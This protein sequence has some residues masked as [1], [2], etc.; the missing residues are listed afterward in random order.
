M[1]SDYYFLNNSQRIICVSDFFQKTSF[2]R[3]N[4]FSMDTLFVND[5][6]ES[7]DEADILLSSYQSW[8][9]DDRNL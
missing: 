6:N 3:F 8:A 1:L 5:E 4:I 9:L 2:V 7:D